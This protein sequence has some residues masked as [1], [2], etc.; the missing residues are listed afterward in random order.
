MELMT[1][2]ERLKRNNFIV[3]MQRLGAFLHLQVNGNLL[4]EDGVMF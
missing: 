4:P 3:D 1:I 2:P